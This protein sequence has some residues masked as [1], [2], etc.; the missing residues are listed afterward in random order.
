MPD[1]RAEALDLGRLSTRSRRLA[2]R[3]F[4]VLPDLRAAASMEGCTPEGWSLRVEAPS[5]TGDSER[6]LIISMED[7]APMVEFAGWH[8][9]GTRR[10][11]DAAERRF[12]AL[13]EAIV[14]DRFVVAIDVGGE[15]DGHRWPVDLRSEELVPAGTSTV[16]VVSWRGTAD[17]GPPA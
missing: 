14:R 12:V 2:D 4:A 17:L 11:S 13:V 7:D 8:G 5:P 1:S 3:L 10:L 9:H 16:R 6:T 15:H